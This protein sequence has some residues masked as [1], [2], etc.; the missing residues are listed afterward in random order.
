MDKKGILD[1]LAEKIRTHQ[2]EPA[3]EML[4]DMNPI[5]IADLFD[6][7]PNDKCLVL[8]RILPKDLSAEVFSNLPSDIQKS[9]VEH[10]SDK[11]IQ[12]IITEMQ[13]DDT[14]DFIEELPANLVKRI[15]EQASPDIRT[16]I[17]IFL[18]YPEDSAG[19]VM[20]V[21]Y[22][23]LRSYM[24][25]DEALAKYKNLANINNNND[26]CFIIGETR[27]LEGVISLKT[28][29]LSDPKAAI[30]D[31]M[32]K[33]V[34]S[35]LAT[36]DQEVVADLFR[37]YDLN[38]MPVTDK[39]NRLVGI[40]TV[41]DIMDVI[42]AESTEDIHK[43]AAIDPSKVEYLKESVWSHSKHRI[44]W[45]V[46]LMISATFTGMIIHKYEEVLESAVMLAAFIPML[47]DTGG[48]AGAQS[49]T[50]VIRGMALGEISSRDF[51]KVIWKE[52]RVSLIVGL[53]LAALNFARVYF[54]DS[55]PLNVIF[56][57]CISLYVTVILAKVVG[58]ILP[59][60]AKW[61][62][63]DPAVMAGPLITTVVD[64]CAL[65]VY[66]WLSV[67]LLTDIIH[68]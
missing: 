13:L 28:M 25:I 11:E 29:V 8:F 42:V 58:S 7:L 47:M 1:E 64:A 12:A 44:T 39:E 41:D 26:I 18:K 46:V 59:M 54:F 21:E 35:V 52:F 31:V 65:M 22:V 20:T 36:E 55:V 56:V 53:L 2:F 50:L 27:K 63:L 10:I 24:T 5:D 34:V 33:N 67:Q 62:K 19:S 66:F 48:N 17:N 61:L 23:A 14:V 45:L 30:V 4:A 9:V 68:V 37:K 32:E 38:S 15:L 49:S 60:A 43:M 57:I 16:Q 40:I 6:D 51:W 3:R